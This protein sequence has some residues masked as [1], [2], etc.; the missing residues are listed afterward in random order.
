MS[1]GR[2][3]PG[4]EPARPSPPGAGVMIGRPQGIRQRRPRPEVSSERREY[5]PIGWLEPPVIPSNLVRIMKGATLPLFGLLTSA[6]HM[7]WLRHIGGRL[8]SDYRY[9]IGLNCPLVA[10]SRAHNARHLARRT[11]LAHRRP[12]RP[13]RAPR[14]LRRTQPPRLGHALSRPLDPRRDPHRPLAACRT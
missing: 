13:A 1:S 9:S 7:S 8:K 4:S 11:P 6:M 14:R 2:P 3:G 5:V 12:R 10:R